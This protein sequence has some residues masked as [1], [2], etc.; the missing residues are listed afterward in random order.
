CH[1]TKALREILIFDIEYECLT[2]FDTQ[3]VILSKFDTVHTNSLDPRDSPTQDTQLAGFAP[4]GAHVLSSSSPGQA[5][6]CLR[7]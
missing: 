6:R 3:F 2:V 4:G 7:P 1:V 5:R